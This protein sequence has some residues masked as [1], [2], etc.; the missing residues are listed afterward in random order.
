MDARNSLESEQESILNEM[1]DI[2]MGRTGGRERGLLG[3][4]AWLF[5]SRLWNRGHYSCAP[6]SQMPDGNEK[7]E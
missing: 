5:Q 1:T 7:S 6:R 4:P 2:S 3:S